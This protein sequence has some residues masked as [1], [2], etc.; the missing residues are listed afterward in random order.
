MFYHSIPSHF[1]NLE[2]TIVTGSTIY[3]D[4]NKILNNNWPHIV[5]FNNLS[6]PTFDT[7]P[8]ITPMIHIGSHLSFLNAAIMLA[9]TIIISYLL[10]K[11]CGLYIP[12]FPVVGAATVDVIELSLDIT[13]I[14]ILIV[15]LIIS[16]TTMCLFRRSA[17]LRTDSK[18]VKVKNLRMKVQA[19]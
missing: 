5:P 2:G 13:I 12:A 3:K 1:T 14:V 8:V 9:L 6:A 15:L 17:L 11:V 10:F 19:L 4:L 7:L 18:K 16:L